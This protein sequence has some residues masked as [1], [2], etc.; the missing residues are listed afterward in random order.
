LLELRS[1]EMER[2]QIKEITNKI[3]PSKRKEV[4]GETLPSQRNATTEDSA[5]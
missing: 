5:R 3:R 4:K 2:T 1:V